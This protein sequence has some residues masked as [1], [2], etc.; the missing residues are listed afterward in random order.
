M[1]FPCPGSVVSG[2]ILAEPSLRMAELIPVVSLFPIY[3][4][5][6]RNAIMMPDAEVLVAQASFRL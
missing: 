5:A 3:S 1:F 6:M 4:R 2:A